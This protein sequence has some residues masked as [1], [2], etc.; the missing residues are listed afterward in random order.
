MMSEKMTSDPKYWWT[1]HHQALLE[2]KQREYVK[3]NFEFRNK[4]N[5]QETVGFEAVLICPVFDHLPLLTS[6]SEDVYVQLHQTFHYFHLVCRPQ[7]LGEAGLH[8]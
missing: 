8:G 3:I 1:S 2:S 4:S 6:L 7:E 5:G